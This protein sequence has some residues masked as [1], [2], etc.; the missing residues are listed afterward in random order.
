[1]E[2]FSIISNVVEAEGERG[3]GGDI[4]GTAERV[5]MRAGRAGAKP[6]A[7]ARRRGGLGKNKQKQVIYY[8]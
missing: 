5:R 6:H 3:G 2:G 8:H 7:E 4:Q 1:M